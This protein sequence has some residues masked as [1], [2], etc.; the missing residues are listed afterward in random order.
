MRMDDAFPVPSHT[1]LCAS[2]LPDGACSTLDVLAAIL[3][4]PFV[5]SLLGAAA[6]PDD[7]KFGEWLA[8][9]DRQVVSD[10]R[11]G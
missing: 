11:K 7:G 5:L 8:G 6:M 9:L 2:S 3:N 4:S 10:L 1:G